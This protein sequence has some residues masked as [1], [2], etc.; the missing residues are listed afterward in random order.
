MAQSTE[1]SPRRAHRA[2]APTIT[3]LWL[4]SRRAST[5][6]IPAPVHSDEEI[7]HWLADLVI[8]GEVWVV[9]AADG[10]IVAMMVVHQDDLDQLY[11]RPGWTGRG[12]G[13][14]LVE[15][16]KDRHPRGLALWTFATNVRAR[17]F[18]ERH[19]FEPGERTDGAENEEGAPAVHYY[20]PGRRQSG[21]SPA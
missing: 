8:N 2:D 12:L 13:S 11:V 21:Q 7:G 18:Y 10:T 9:E 6:A 4:Q 17:R 1:P 20:W 14:S 16:A 5:P 15:L 3:E 19:G